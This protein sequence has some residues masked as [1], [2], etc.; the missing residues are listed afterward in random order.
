MKQ[1]STREGLDIVVMQSFSERFTGAITRPVKG[2]NALLFSP[3]GSIHTFFMRQKIDVVFLDRS[4]LV[5]KYKKAL[6]PWRVC[7]APRK[8]RYVLELNAHMARGFGLKPGN[9]INLREKYNEI[10]TD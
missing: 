2:K 6:S 7:L 4:G 8:T 5:L 10:L 9:R 1:L 3:G